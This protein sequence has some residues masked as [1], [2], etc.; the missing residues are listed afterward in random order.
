MYIIIIMPQRDF[1]TGGVSVCLTVRSSH[2]SIAPKLNDRRITRFS[3][4]VVQ[5]L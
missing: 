4:S 5:G 2:A 3:I 1:A